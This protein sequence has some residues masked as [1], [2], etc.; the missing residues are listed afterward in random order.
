MKPNLGRSPSETRAL[1]LTKKLSNA[2]LKGIS[3]ILRAV[4]DSLTEAGIPD[5]SFVLVRQ[6]S[7]ARNGQVV[8]AL[9]DDEATIK[10]FRR[11][12]DVVT[13]VPRSSNLRHKSIVVTRDF[14]VQGV[15]VATIHDLHF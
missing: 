6:Q 12:G 11:T 13:L 15:I 7:S 9:V 14:L 3:Q 1:S 4:G 10:E 2:D 8:V 5:G